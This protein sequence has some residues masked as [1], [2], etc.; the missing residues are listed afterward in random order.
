MVA[1]FLFLFLFLCVCVC[2]LLK[3]PS[4][5]TLMVTRRGLLPPQSR[6]IIILEHFIHTVLPFASVP[7][8]RPSSVSSFHCLFLSVHGE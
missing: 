1:P 7:S 2:V 4:S 3:L 8:L 6:I 5:L